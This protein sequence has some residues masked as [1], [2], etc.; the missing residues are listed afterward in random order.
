MIYLNEKKY[1]YNPQ[2]N[3]NTGGFGSVYK[4]TRVTDGLPVAIKVI[5]KKHFKGQ[6]AP[7]MQEAYL[8]E[9]KMQKMAT[10][11]Q[12][13]FFV[14]Y[15]DNFK[16]DINVYLIMEYCECDLNVYVASHVISELKAL[17][18]TFQICLG[19]KFLHSNHITH[20]DIKPPN[21]LL[22]DHYF[23]IGDFGCAKASEQ[24]K[25]M[26]GTFGYMAPE[27]YGSKNSF[28][29]KIDIW[30]LNTCLYF[31]LTKKLYF[32]GDNIVEMLKTLKER[33]FKIEP[34][35]SS[36]RPETKDLLKK[37]YL[38]DPGQ[39]PDVCAYLE[40]PAFDFLRAKYK[41]FLDPNLDTRSPGGSK[42]PD[43]FFS[44]ERPKGQLIGFGK[45]VNYISWLS[46]FQ[47]NNRLYLR[48]A[49][50]LMN[51]GS[52]PV[53]AFLLHKRAAQNI[54]DLDRC[55]SRG[56]PPRFRN[57]AKIKFE[58]EEW[59]ACCESG[60]FVNLRSVIREEAAAY[61]NRF[62]EACKKL[63]KEFLG[64][65]DV[66]AELGSDEP[67]FLAEYCCELIEERMIVL[68]N[69]PSPDFDYILRLA[70][71]IFRF[72]GDFA[73]DMV[74]YYLRVKEAVSADGK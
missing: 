59:N 32:Q 12:L 22:K 52:S 65:A 58:P 9:I 60:H 2:Q 64:G 17:D 44:P 4:G 25:T 50:E 39:R 36:L 24:L 40:H 15:I 10:D 23:K 5:S 70:Q 49:K 45:N 28:T 73:D 71:S 41:K 51:S 38:K 13:P 34:E 21:I 72:E 26:T 68:G 19:L 27:F 14:V 55:L 56:E 47:N 69:E 67:L 62:L 6:N 37:G 74:F 31:M 18:I 46:N 8:R 43:D 54:I 48:L 29:P 1:C 42:D 63:N 30:A 33:E 66:S 53:L 11:L 3:F 7:Q 16:D 20:R 61:K 35:L 57:F